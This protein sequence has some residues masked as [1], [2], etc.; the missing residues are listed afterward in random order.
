MS[1]RYSRANILVLINNIGF[2]PQIARP[3]SF[4]PP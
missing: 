4:L 1:Y 2:M 3:V